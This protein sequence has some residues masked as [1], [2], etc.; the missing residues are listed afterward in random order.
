MQ[1]NSQIEIGGVSNVEMIDTFFFA[2]NLIDD[3]I[4]IAGWRLV[5]IFLIIANKKILPKHRYF[6]YLTGW[7]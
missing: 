1:G 5:H 6:H 7:V 3:C 4:L 2:R